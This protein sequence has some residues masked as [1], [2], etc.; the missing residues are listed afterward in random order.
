MTLVT[1]GHL[2]FVKVALK[3]KKVRDPCSRNFRCLWKKKVSWWIHLALFRKRPA[4]EAVYLM[5]LSAHKYFAPFWSHVVT[6]RAVFGNLGNLFS[7]PLFLFLGFFLLQ[8][9]KYGFPDGVDTVIVKVNSE[10]NFP[11]SVMSIQD[12][13]VTHTHT[14]TQSSS[15]KFSL[16][17]C[18]YVKLLL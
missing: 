10:K 5:S 9:F 3:G 6:V 7:F 13:Q 15:S 1:V 12:I 4:C 8:F 16:Y 14:I 18:L 17:L 2:N 11:C